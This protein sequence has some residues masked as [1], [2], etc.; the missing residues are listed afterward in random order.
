VGHYVNIRDL[1][2]SLFNVLPVFGASG[3]FKHTQDF[4][5]VR[6]PAQGTMVFN[7]EIP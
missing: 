4:S 5:S 3:K 6:L 1:I 7:Q 2:D